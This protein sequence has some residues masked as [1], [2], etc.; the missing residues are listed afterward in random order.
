MKTHSKLIIA[1]TA[2]AAVLAGGAA[3]TPASAATAAAE[4]QITCATAVKIA[5]KKVPGAR[6][7]DV[8]REWEHGHRTCKVELVKGAY[9]YDVYV[10]LSTGKIVKFDRD[11]D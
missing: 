5:K 3:L 7:T 8:E 4:R 2:A 6:V 10:S 1:G 11:R 9:E